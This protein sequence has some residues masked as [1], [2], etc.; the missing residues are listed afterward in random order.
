MKA[1][2]GWTTYWRNGKCRFYK[3][4]CPVTQEYFA[5]DLAPYTFP[6]RREAQAH[7][8]LGIG[9]YQWRA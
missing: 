3:R 1:P 9:A 5:A 6:T 4:D 8:Q 7:A 2:Y